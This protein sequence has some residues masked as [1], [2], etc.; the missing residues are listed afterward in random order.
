MKAH[1]AYHEWR[2]LMGVLMTHIFVNIVNIPPTHILVLLLIKKI[3]LQTHPTKSGKC[4]PSFS[5]IS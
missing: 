1:D 2:E 3:N 5:P 4:I